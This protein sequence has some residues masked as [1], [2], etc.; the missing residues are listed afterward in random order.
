[1]KGPRLFSPRLSQ[2]RAGMLCR[3]YDDTGVIITQLDRVKNQALIGFNIGGPLERYDWTPIRRI[4]IAWSVGT[5]SEALLL[6][7]EYNTLVTE[8]FPD[9]FYDT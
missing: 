4:R 5:L 1:M 3:L 9:L 2:L 8:K 7:Q 6:L